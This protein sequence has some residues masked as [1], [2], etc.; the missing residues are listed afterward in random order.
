VT[1]SELDKLEAE[2]NEV[3]EARSWVYS[4]AL[5]SSGRA[6]HHKILDDFCKRDLINET[7]SL[8]TA[9]R[10]V[11]EALKPFAIEAGEWH[12]EAGANDEMQI[13]VC[14]AS[15][16]DQRGGGIA[17]FTVGDLRRAADTMK[18]KP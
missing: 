6:R 10:K 13:Y 4:G 18:D 7:L 15:G 1:P 8:I 12:R 5:S 14:P 11:L 9:H 17:K 16:E 2:L 3:K